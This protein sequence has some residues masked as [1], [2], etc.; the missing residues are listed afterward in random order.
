MVCNLVQRCRV[1]NH[2]GRAFGLHDLLLLQICEQ[3]RNRLSRSS[4]RLRDFLVREPRRQPRFRLCRLNEQK[5]SLSLKSLR[6]GE[7]IDHY[8]DH[9]LPRLSKSARKG[10]Q[11]YIKNW[12]EPTWHGHVADNM[13]TMQVRDWLDKIELPDG[14]KPKIKNILSA[15]FSHGVRWEIRGTQPR[16]RSGRDAWPPRRLNWRKA[17]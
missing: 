10:N 17:E 14:T 1:A 12:I 9:E 11:S 16:L 2:K 5:Q 6:F 4:D 15:I 13:K 7:L 8:L 3:P